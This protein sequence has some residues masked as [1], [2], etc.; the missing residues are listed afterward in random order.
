M[1]QDLV[2]TPPET[3]GISSA[4][5][6]DF[7][8][9][10]DSSVTEMHGL[11]LL[12]HGNIVAKG[13][14]APYAE[15]LP[16]MLFSL[17][18]SF[19]STAVGF[20][21]SEGRLS[22]DD[23]VASFFP[24]KLPRF[25]SGNLEAM[26]IR[27]LLTMST[28][29][30]ADPTER[31]RS[32]GDGDWVA[33]FFEAP[34]EREPGTL[35]L[36]NSAASHVLSAIVQKVSGQTLLDYLTPRL[37]APLGIHPDSWETDPRGINTGSSGLMIRTEEIARFGQLYLQKGMWNG[38][39]VLPAA[40]IAEATSRQVSNRT[41]NEAEPEHDWNQGYGYQ[42]WRCRHGAYRADGA[43]GQ[44]CIVFPE[45]DA[46]LAVNS[47]VSE[48]HVALSVVWDKLLP[49]F[50][51]APLPLAA[52][53]ERALG[54]RLSALALSA[55]DSK[56]VSPCAARIS[57]TTYG[58]DANRWEIEA[59]RVEAG[60]DGCIIHIRD[61]KLD[62]RAGCAYAGW[63]FTQSDVFGACQQPLAGHAEWIQPDT[64][65]LTLRKYVTPFVFT[66]DLCFKDE[67]VLLAAR[68]NVNMGPTEVPP[69]RGTATRGRAAPGRRARGMAPRA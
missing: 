20:A 28:G 45:Q 7:I 51:P 27:H 16:H 19:T 49:A 15:D 30:T 67:Q 34:V 46:V 3:Q 18:K 41:A 25:I 38:Q 53:N 40:W 42:F 62:K 65:R 23:P 56:P 35:F 69:V 8:D 24:D 6:L 48:M 21:A 4:V 5:L 47:A 22:I 61:H 14:W 63:R 55:P 36:Y 32:R 58:M 60:P 17:T 12:R 31:S 1:S 9:T 11:V 68:M 29:H 54:E 33:G 66:V 37:F 57:G 59:L 44:F 26:R 52:S 64:L 39:Q 43:F 2:R 13:W 50:Q 10:L